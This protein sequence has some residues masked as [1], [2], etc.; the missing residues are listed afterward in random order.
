MCVRG[1]FVKKQKATK[2]KNA[3]KDWIFKTPERAVPLVEQYNR[4]FNSVRPRE[5]D[6]SALRFPGM[7]SSITLREHQKNTE[8]MGIDKLV[9]DELHECTTRS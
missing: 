4:Q 5:Y 6:G 2:L 8:E 1:I 3:F 9:V 7:N